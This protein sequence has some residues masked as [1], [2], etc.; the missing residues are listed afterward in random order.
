LGNTFHLMLRPGVEVIE[1]H[2]G[3]HDFTHWQG[4]IL[5]DSG[6]FQIFSLATFRKIREEGVRFRSHIDGSYHNLTPED[7]V[8]VQEA[9]GSDIQMC[10]DVCTPPE[11]SHR[12]ALT[13]LNITSR[14]AGRAKKRW[15]ETNENYHGKLFGIVQGNFYKDLRKQSAEEIMS[16]ELPGVAIGGLSVGES[17]NKFV[18]F[19]SYSAEFLPEDKPGYLMGVGTPDYILEA[20]ENGIDLFDCVYGTRIARNGTI[21]TKNGLVALKKAFHA[22]DDTPLEDGCICRAC[23][24]YS[25]GYMRHLFKT[26]EILGPMLATEHNLHF[27]YSFVKDIRTSI[28]NGTF[29]K[30]KKEFLKNYSSKK[31]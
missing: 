2:G 8:M 28:E 12:E 17:Y 31:R 4:P 29:K 5:T 24:Q 19:L 22:M 18:E 1:A 26:N 21:F 11:I 7:V 6:G 30:F 16:L 3:L 25:R 20:V 9:L 14:W 10:L 27:L 23:T 13:A 15:L